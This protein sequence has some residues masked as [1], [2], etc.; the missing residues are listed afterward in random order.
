MSPSTSPTAAHAMLAGV[1][2]VSLALNLPGPAA[3]MRLRSLGARC[4]KVEAPAPAG[5]ATSDPMAVYEARA[6]AEMH[7]GVEVVQ[8]N[9][10][11]PQGQQ[12]LH[13]LLAQADVLLTSFRPA[14]MARL[15]LDAAALQARHPRLN[16]VQIVGALGQGADGS[17][18][19]NEAGHDLTYQAEAGLVPGMEMPASLLADMAGALLT[20]EAVLACLLARERS[21]AGC[22]REVALLDGARWLAI[23]RRWGLTQPTAILGGQHA[24]YRIYPCLDGR[25]AVAALEPHF[26]LRLWQQVLIDAGALG[27]AAQAEAAPDMLA[28]DTR[29]A[30]ARFVAGR[31]CAQLEALA[32]RHDV[33]L[34]PMPDAP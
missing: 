15:G 32:A 19:A 18:R 30:I 20:S 16:V 34:Y 26:A 24:G 33:P 5:A 21:G 6:Y 3:L 12:R 7:E 11:S 2:I 25:V 9:L 27:D 8:A 1:H 4:T 13:V 17:D 29:A 31:S 14:A 10:K 28:D 23:P 22:V